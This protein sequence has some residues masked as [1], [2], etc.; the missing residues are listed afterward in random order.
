MGK[1]L[2]IV[3]T[4]IVIL[5]FLIFSWWYKNLRIVYECPQGESVGGILYPPTFDC[6]PLGGDLHP[7][8]SSKYLNW[9]KENCPG[10]TVTW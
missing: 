7:R 5:G 10:F 4:F 1:K 8:C 9:A 2:K 3:L 6:Q